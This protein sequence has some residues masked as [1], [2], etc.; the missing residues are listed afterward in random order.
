MKQTKTRKFLAGIKSYMIAKGRREHGVSYRA[1][2]HILEAYD[3]GPE[4]L[5]EELERR[6]FAWH[7][8][9]GEWAEKPR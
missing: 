2:K 3:M 5:Y 1:L 4:A 7:T 9:T 8:E 6:G